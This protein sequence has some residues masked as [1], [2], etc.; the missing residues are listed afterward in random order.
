MAP[1]PL[2]QPEA[3][4]LKQQTAPEVK[5]MMSAVTDAKILRHWTSSTANTLMVHQVARDAS[6]KTILRP[7]PV[8]CDI[9]DEDAAMER[10]VAELE[11]MDWHASV[12]LQL[13]IGRLVQEER[14]T[15]SPEQLAREIGLPAR[16]ASDRDANARKVWR[17][18]RV[19][20]FLAVEGERQGWTAR[21]KGGRIVP[22]R[23][24]DPLLVVT[25]TTLVPGTDLPA[26][27][28]IAC[29]RWLNEM[30]KDKRHLP[31]FGDVRRVAAI[32]GGKPS[33]AWAQC[34]AFA[35]QQQWR[36][37][38]NKDRDPERYVF[39]RYSLL[40][41]PFCAQPPV[42]ELLSDVHRNAVRAVDYWQRAVRI[43]NERGILSPDAA[44]VMSRKPDTSAPGWKDRWLYEEFAVLPHGEDWDDTLLLRQQKRDA[45]SRSRRQRKQ[46]STPKEQ[47]KQ[48][49]RSR[50]TVE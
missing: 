31:D 10:L 9:Q 13:C 20:A 37:A 16:Y 46:T 39:S 42:G 11:A 40:V 32:S 44:A 21:D 43:L 24:R 28:E 34:M 2:R 35:F 41:E 30:R 18:L 8:F 19:F 23:V 3:S 49:V 25:G 22:V 4:R 6:H 27:L 33:G 12:L 36:G 47:T 38:A 29:S 15:T 17:W 48:P 14:F 45:M 50:R 5:E 1:P 7:N 26:E